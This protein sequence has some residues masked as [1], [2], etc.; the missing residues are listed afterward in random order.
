VPS[1]TKLTPSDQMWSDKDTAAYL[2]VSEVTVRRLRYRGVLPY[3]KVGAAV[4][5]PRSAVLAYAAPQTDGG[6]A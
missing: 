2:R 5:I 4:R 6:A 3:T 1:T